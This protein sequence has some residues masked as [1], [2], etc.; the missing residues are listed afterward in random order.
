MLGYGAAASASL[1]NLVAN[2][3]FESAQNNPAAPDAWAAAG[4]RAIKQT[5][6]LDVGRDGG[7]CAKLE[8]AQFSGYGAD[9]HA[10]ICQT[11]HIAVRKGQWYRLSFQ[12]KASG[13][14]GAVEVSLISRR[15]W[16]DIGLNEVFV[17]SGRWEKQEFLFQASD[18]LSGSASR[19]QF[20]FRSTGTL[21]LDDVELKESAEGAQW[22]PQISSEG[23]KNFLP[24]ASFEC[25]AANWGSLTMGLKGWAGDLFRLEGDLDDSVAQHGTTSLRISSANPPI[26]NFDYYDATRQPV[27]RVLVANKG[28]IRVKPGERLTFS[29]SVRSDTD[30]TKILLLIQEAPEHIQRKEVSAGRQWQRH[31]FTFTPAASLLFVAI[32]PD[33][34]SSATPATVWL[35]A[36]QLER[37]DKATPFEPRTPVESFIRSKTNVFF[38]TN[39]FVTIHAYNDTKEEQPLSGRVRTA[40]FFD[41]TVYEAGC[42]FKLPAHSRRQMA[43]NPFIASREGF[44][45]VSWATAGSTQSVRCVKTTNID[46]DS[47]DSP[48]G[49]NHAYPWDFLLQSARGAGIGSWRDWSAKWDTV[50]RTKGKFDFSDVDP[51]VERVVSQGGELTALLAF[52]SASWSSA[53]SERDI[54]QMAGDDKGRA[55]Q[56]RLASMP[57]DIDDFAKYAGAVAAHYRKHLAVSHFEILNE[58]LYTDYALP[59]Q[60]GY[61]MDDYLKIVRAAAVALRAANPAC[62]IIGGAGSGPENDLTRQFITD[63]GLDLVDILN[64]HMYDPPLPPEDF[65]KAFESLQTLMRARGQPKPIWIT[66]WGCYADDDPARIPQ[67]VGDAT[68]KHCVWPSERAATENLV[69]FTAVSFAHGVRKIFFHA[70]VCGAINGEDSAGVFFEYGGEPRKMYAGSAALTRILGVPTECLGTFHAGAFH[71]FVFRHGAR[72]VAIAWAGREKSKELELPEAITALDVM[73]NKLE[74]RALSFG[75]T[76]VY[77]QAASASDLL[78]FFRSHISQLR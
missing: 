64:L 54:Q 37:G 69:K 43:L 50:E 45:R 73:G 30:R 76:P 72:S 36:L 10:M 75:S 55:A 40:D 74:Q 16:K 28:W 3:S 53:A 11:D 52:P 25:G 46:L 17:P 4:N 5:L 42:D 56:L 58:P 6:S 57:R 2:G 9:Y 41:Q 35:D 32:G 51:Q 23:V 78:E 59:R 71:A 61:S 24:N 70:G 39:D 68:M 47:H 44:F 63:G 8:C 34:E 18:E 19:L 7:R 48:L 27:H 49:M 62:Q 21:W 13:I 15:P 14:Q 66:E 22:F 38:G 77:L 26:F 65:E 60:L 31:E 1:E 33:F 29:A 12:A 67:T 20:W